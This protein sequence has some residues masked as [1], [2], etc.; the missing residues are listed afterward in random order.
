[1]Q[2]LVLRIDDAVY[3]R[4]LQPLASAGLQPELQ[5][6]LAYVPAAQRAHADAGVAAERLEV[7]LAALRYGPLQSAWSARLAP[8][9][10]GLKQL[11]EVDAAVLE[12][13]ADPDDRDGD[14]I[15]GRVAR[16]PLPDGGTAIGRFGWKAE[17]V[18]LR[19]QVASAFSLDLGLGSPLYPSA[20]GDCTQAQADCL[21]QVPGTSTGPAAEE[22]DA[23]ILELILAYLES[24]PA[25]L[26]A[27]TP[28]SAAA[29]VS[30]GV[31]AAATAEAS[32]G[33]A[34]FAQTGCAACH[35]PQLPTSAGPV[36][37]YTDLLL[38]DL[39]Q[40]LAD[41]ADAESAQAAEWR[42]A[43]LWGVGAAWRLLH[44]GRASSVEDAILW[45]D[46][47]AAA[48]RAAYQALAP[49]QRRQLLDFIQGL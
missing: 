15:S 34:L 7:G 38:H 35:L 23:N 6:Q 16:V 1:M 9:L 18:D 40:G 31:A 48:A 49:A 39:G 47:E 2:A 24:L 12:A 19:Q 28:V 21:Q 20:H 30:A 8:A 37:A 14:G 4:Q 43:P 36:A 32:I 42:T 33:P 10:A 46:G 17:T 29:P 41:A 44:D 27:A 22:L 25:P 11:Q 3:G 26:S 45:H 13:L 5:L